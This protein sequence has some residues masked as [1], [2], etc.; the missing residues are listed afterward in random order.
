MMKININDVYDTIND[1]MRCV[2]EQ[3]GPVTDPSNY[4]WVLGIDIVKAIDE[5]CSVEF[6]K[7]MIRTLLGIDIKVDMSDPNIIQLHRIIST[8]HL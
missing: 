4:Q 1:D 3:Y 6:H 8:C 5:M 2:V 7:D